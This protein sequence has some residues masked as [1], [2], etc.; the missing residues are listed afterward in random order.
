MQNPPEGAIINYYLKSA[1]SGPVTLEILHGGR[2]ARA[3][4]LERRSVAP[5]PDPDA[6]A[7]LPL[8]WY[9]Q[10]QALVDGAGHASLHVGRA[11]SAAA[12]GGGGGGGGGLPIA[13]VPYN[14]VPAPTTPWVNPGTYTVKLTVERQDA[15]R[16][17]SR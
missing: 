9:R 8:Y 6:D 15:T 14:T 2:P 13:A 1:A 5:L 12:G 3:P 4:L 16:S 17:R 11:L 10:P 7:P